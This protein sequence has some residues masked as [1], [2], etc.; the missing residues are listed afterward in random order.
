MQ[1]PIF[2]L[3]I[4]TPEDRL[5]MQNLYIEYRPIMVLEAKRLLR[6]GEAEDAV[7]DAFV[8]L[9]KHIAALQSFN[10]CKLRSYIVHTVRNTC[11][12]KLRK[13]KRDKLYTFSDPDAALIRAQADEPDVDDRLIQGA[14]IKM[15]EEAMKQLPEKE[16]HLLQMKYFAQMPD[17][18]IAGVLGIKTASVRYYLT[19]ARRHVAA[20]IEEAER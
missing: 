3:A 10:V 4:E 1:Y 9:T 13:V 20:I 6:G 14:E 8:H 18:E 16:L 5:F 15:L 19:L 7:H 17:A 2:L 11:Y 12:D